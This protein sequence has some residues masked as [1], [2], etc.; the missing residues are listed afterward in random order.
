M[1]SKSI[2]QAAKKEVKYIYFKMKK[3]Q[4]KRKLKPV[5]TSHDGTRQ[6]PLTTL[7]KIVEGSVFHEIIKT[8][9]SEP[10]LIFTNRSTSF[11]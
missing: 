9:I 5:K 11:V 3:S 1:Q 8:R 10:D 6:V 7:P 2:F 4:I